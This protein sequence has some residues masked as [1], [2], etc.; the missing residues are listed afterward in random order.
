MAEIRKPLQKLSP[1]HKL[2]AKEYVA[3]GFNASEAYRR[4]Y[5]EDNS[6][7]SRLAREPLIQEE[8]DREMHERCEALRINE[9]RV[10]MKLAEMAF[11][12]KEDE[13]YGP[14]V[15]LK[16]IDMIQKQLGLQK[17][18]I[19]ANVDQTTTITVTIDEE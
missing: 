1:Q 14:S 7:A 5:G 15:Q 12:D 17:Q 19:D 2:F 16:A 3:C 6:N 11:A 10:L 4:V 8:I 9:D 13:V 18:K